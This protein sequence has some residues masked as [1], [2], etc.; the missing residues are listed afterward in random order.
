MFSS[1]PNIV[2]PWELWHMFVDKLVR[3]NFH[4]FANKNILIFLSTFNFPCE[5]LKRVGHNWC[6]VITYFKPKVRVLVVRNQ[7][8]CGPSSTIGTVMGVS[9][10]SKFQELKLEDSRSCLYMEQRSKLDIAYMFFFLKACGSRQPWQTCVWVTW[11]GN[12]F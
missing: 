8:G 7:Y 1:N 9:K 4:P 2:I 10:F 3:F 12:F 5:Y 6:W 11:M